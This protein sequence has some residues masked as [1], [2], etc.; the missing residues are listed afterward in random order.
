VFW[1]VGGV[2]FIYQIIRVKQIRSLYHRQMA[3]FFSVLLGIAILSF[4]FESSTISGLWL[5]SLWPFCIYL[6]DFISRMKKKLWFQISFWLF[7]LI[8]ISIYIMRITL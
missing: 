4:Y 1:L 6:G 5:L 8:P 3:T 7:V 2:F